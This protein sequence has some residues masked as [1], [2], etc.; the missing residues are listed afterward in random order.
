VSI[1]ESLSISDHL[2]AE[3]I[4]GNQA[5]DWK[6][7]WKL[8]QDDIRLILSPHTEAMSNESIHASLH[9]LFSF[10]ILTYHM[11]DALNVAATGLGLKPSE[12]EDAITNDARLA[13]LADLANLD[14]HMRLTLPPRSGT[15]PVIERVS[16]VD[17]QV[18]GGG[19]QLSVRIRHGASVLDGIAVAE[20][21]VTAWQKRL[22][23]WRLI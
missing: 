19:W 12:V 10:F 2:G 13:L 7:R 5:R 11:K 4:L 9:H 1:V 15:V 14:K 6:Q 3:L 8:I 17:N 23:S 20:G 22:K 18:G 16:G 21:A